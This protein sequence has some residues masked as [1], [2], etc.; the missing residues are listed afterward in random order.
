MAHESD[1]PGFA[2]EGSETATDF[3]AEFFEQASASS[4]IVD[5]LRESDAIEVGE[6]WRGDVFETEIFETF[7]E[8][9][10]PM[11]M[12]GP[13]GFESFFEHDLA[14]FA[15]GVGHVD[16]G[17]V[18]V[19]AI[20][21][22]VAA[23]HGEVEVPVGD[24]G[25]AAIHAGQG[26]R[27]EGDGGEPRGAGKVLLGAGV[28]GIDTETIDGDF[29]TSEA[30]HGIDDEECAVF[31]DDTGDFIE[32][33][34]EAGAGFGLDDTE[35]LDSGMLF[36]GLGDLIGLDGLSPRGFNGVDGG[37]VSAGDIGHA[38]PEDTGG[39]DEDFV[40]GFDEIAEAGFH[41]GGSG[42]GD[43]EGEFVLGLEDL[44]EEF[45][46][47]IHQDQIFGIEMAEGGSGEGLEDTLGDLA[48]P[49]SHENAFRGMKWL[50]ARGHPCPFA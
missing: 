29:H 33:L 16:G 2:F 4:G 43:G 22:P 18:V 28:A 31:L 32:G 15:K 14:G 38:R 8:G 42:S 12:A 23:D 11:L 37:A 9:L 3:D 26:I 7:S 1:A 39:S 40:T 49:G 48:W 19:D 34:V 35:E 17:G 20:A 6:A 44:L 24:F 30:R 27:A 36:E 50:E 13:A 5:T 25:F 46:E 41:P 21:T 47:I 10:V 45:L